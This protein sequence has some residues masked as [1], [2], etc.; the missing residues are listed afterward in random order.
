MKALRVML[1]LFFGAVFFSLNT[2]EAGSQFV[3]IDAQRIHSGRGAISFRVKL[4]KDIS[5]DPHNHV[6]MCGNSWERSECFEIEIIEEQLI[7]RRYFHQCMLSVYSVRYNFT[8]GEWHDV[9]L[10]WEQATTRLFIDG[11]EI[12]TGKLVSTDD[13]PSGLYPC[14]RVG[15]DQNFNIS[16]FRVS[17]SANIF[18]DP[19]A[20]EFV[21][22]TACP[23]LNDLLSEQPQKQCRGIQ[24]HHFPDQKSR[25]IIASYIMALPEDVTRSIKHVVFVDRK[26][27]SGRGEGGLADSAKEAVFLEEQWYSDPRVFFHEAAHLYDGTRAIAIG[28][29]DDKSEWAAISGA[30]CYY[31]GGKTEVLIENYLKN[32]EKNAFLAGQAGQ[33]AFEDLA[34]WVGEV[35]YRYLNKKTFSDMLD[36]SSPHY[37]AKVRRKLD[38]LLQ[39]GFFSRDVYDKVTSG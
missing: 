16:D 10:A 26:H 23:C 14:T 4:V 22:N 3:D 5:R 6:L 37:N 15:S 18:T 39:K 9:R 30:S 25:D 1:L 32:N 13:L 35:Y 2:C 11:R 24:L 8:V 21:R 34:V 36:S 27:A 38:F 12:Q 29:P 28:V 20:L 31:K 33:C 17:E 7:T 19:N